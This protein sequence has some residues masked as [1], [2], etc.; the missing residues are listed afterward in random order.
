MKDQNP[1]NILIIED[2]M[3]DYLLIKDY[4]EEQLE[5]PNIVHSKKYSEAMEVLNAN[6][7]SFDVDC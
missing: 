3:G 7:N 5:L 6:A 1:I 4:L 2:N